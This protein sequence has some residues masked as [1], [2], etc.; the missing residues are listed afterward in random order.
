[1]AVKLTT[2]V[3]VCN[4]IAASS[5]TRWLHYNRSSLA[6]NNRRHSKGVS[7][8]CAQNLHFIAPAGSASWKAAAMMWIDREANDQLTSCSVSVFCV[9]YSTLNWVNSDRSRCAHQSSSL[10]TVARK[11]SLLENAALWLVGND[12]LSWHPGLCVLAA[13]TLVS[14]ARKKS[15]K[16]MLIFTEN[17]YDIRVDYLQQ[18]QRC[19]HWQT[20]ISAD[21]YMSEFCRLV[22]APRVPQQATNSSGLHSHGASSQQLTAALWSDVARRCDVILSALL[23]SNIEGM[24][25]IYVCSCQVI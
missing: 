24:Y 2:T 8:V 20:Y 14:L 6:G 13:R 7:H 11:Y 3:R 16:E 22:L 17:E 1:M 19:W 23:L 10:W 9:G 25:V 18:Q 12:A 21:G 4:A 5:V 15:V